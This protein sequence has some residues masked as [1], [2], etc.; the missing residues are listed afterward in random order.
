MRFTGNNF[1]EI[2]DLAMSGNLDRETFQS[3][4]LHTR[5]RIV[6][7]MAGELSVN[8]RVDQF[9]I[10]SQSLARLNCS[11]EISDDYYEWQEARR[12]IL[13]R[14]LKQRRYRSTLNVFKHW[15]KASGEARQDALRT[16]SNM[17]QKV[18]LE[19]MVPVISIKH[20]FSSRSPK[21]LKEGMVLL[22]L[23]TFK[24][25]LAKGSGRIRQNIAEEANFDCPIVALNT[26]HHE[27]TH[28]IHFSLAHEYHQG[29][30]RPDHPLYEDARYF[31]A[32]EVRHVAIQ[33][34]H[35]SLHEIQAFEYLAETEGCAISQTVCELAL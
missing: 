19:G 25:D 34:M 31:H 29:R 24:G 18:Y 32:I 1:N 15:T 6:T 14:V 17:H 23:G 8:P 9:G 2:F 26:A 21:Q 3:I 10:V 28:G 16:T 12:K 20:T 7:A 33:P 35:S 11:F 4:S 5:C 30:I 27:M 22:L 13:E